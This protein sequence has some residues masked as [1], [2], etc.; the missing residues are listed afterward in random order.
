MV[1]FTGIKYCRLLKT[2]WV[3][4]RFSFALFLSNAGGL[5]SEFLAIWLRREDNAARG[6]GR[7]QCSL[8][9]SQTRWEGVWSLQEWGRWKS[10]ASTLWHHRNTTPVAA[11]GSLNGL[12]WIGTFV[13]TER[14]SAQSVRSLFLIRREWILHNRA[15]KTAKGGTARQKRHCCS[16]NLSIILCGRLQSMTTKKHGFFF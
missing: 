6:S 3:W 11:R 4:Y 5:S 10:R 14:P 13:Q 7:V 2:S 12:C 8:G 1:N 16:L 9:C 15:G